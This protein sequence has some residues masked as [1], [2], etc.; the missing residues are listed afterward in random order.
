MRTSGVW[1]FCLRQSIKTGEIYFGVLENM[2]FGVYLFGVPFQHYVFDH[3]GDVGR[4][5]FADWADLKQK[6]LIQGDYRRK[7]NDF[8]NPIPT[9]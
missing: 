3:T 5:E 2:T 7:S 6:Y 1:L 8:P 9:S 4:R